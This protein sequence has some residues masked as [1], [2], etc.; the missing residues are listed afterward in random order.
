MGV[1]GADRSLQV[2]LVSI[3]RKALLTAHEHLLKFRNGRDW[4]AFQRAKGLEI[5]TA[6]S[7]G[8]RLSDSTL[9]DYTAEDAILRTL[10][11]EGRKRRLHVLSRDEMLRSVGRPAP[12]GSRHVIGVLGEEF[13][14]AENNPGWRGLDFVEPDCDILALVD[15]LDGTVLRQRDL[16]NWCIAIAFYARESAEVLASLVSQAVGDL[17]FATPDG[18]AFRQSLDFMNPIREGRLRLGRPRPIRPKPFT[19][20]S[21][22]AFV[23]QKPDSFVRMAS[24][25]RMLR[26]FD[27]VYNLGGNPMLA[28]LADGSINAVF[29][30]R[31]HRA[32]DVVPGA[33]I[34]R[35]A[36][37]V[38]CDLDGRSLDWR[39]SL[40]HPDHPGRSGLLS[41]V[42]AADSETARRVLASLP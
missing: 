31:G 10:I 13:M 16:P 20:E 35:K 30:P 14:K 21:H 23:A 2:D 19:S 39:N 36:G 40:L 5:E 37:A 32:H 1:P 17:Y 6:R 26:H 33:F 7:L 8:L 11:E 25:G 18:G 9:D 28:K 22:L 15:P 3:G 41:Y 34:A 29:E 38:V 12:R 4:E 42:A 24:F 27:R